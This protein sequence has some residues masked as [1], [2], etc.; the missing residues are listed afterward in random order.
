M[1]EKEARFAEG[2]TGFFHESGSKDQ[3]KRTQRQQREK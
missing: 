1:D 2:T 3:Q